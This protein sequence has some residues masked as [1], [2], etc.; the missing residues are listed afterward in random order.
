MGGR[1]DSPRQAADDDQAGPGQIPRQSAGRGQAGRRGVPRP[2]DGHGGTRRATSASPSRPEDDRRVD[3]LGQHGPDS[4]GRAGDEG[5]RPDTRQRGAGAAPR[6]RRRRACSAAARTVGPRL[7]RGTQSPD[8]RRCRP[9]S[10][11]ISLNSRGRPGVGAAAQQR[12]GTTASRDLRRSCPEFVTRTATTVQ[13]ACHTIV[14][15]ESADREC[16]AMQNLQSVRGSGLA[17]CATRQMP[18]GGR[19]GT[20]LYWA[21]NTSCAFTLWLVL[22]LVVGLV[23]AGVCRPALGRQGAG[24]LRHHGRAARPLEGGGVSVGEGRRDS[25]RP[26][27]PPGT[28]SASATSSW[29]ASTTRGKAYE[30]AL[31]VE[32]NNTYIRNNYDLFREIYDRQNRR[33]DR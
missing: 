15:R 21:R 1:V 17:V 2:D 30:K 24:R 28:T 14:G 25:T 5:R 11:R 22:A 31:E 9:A 13:P 33:R 4:P 7:E 8:R 10:S 32:P 29:A 19:P 3:D 12:R 6:L 20:G 18:G 23:A 26:T 27:A 16:R